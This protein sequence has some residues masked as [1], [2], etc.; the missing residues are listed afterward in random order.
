MILAAFL[1]AAPLSL[2][3]DSVIQPPEAARANS[4][5]PQRHAAPDI[6]R[7][8]QIMRDEQVKT[9]ARKAAEAARLAALDRLQRVMDRPLHELLDAPPSPPPPPPAPLPTYRAPSDGP[10]ADPTRERSPLIRCD[11]EPYRAPDTGHRWIE[12]PP[13]WLPLPAWA[14]F[15]AVAGLVAGIGAWLSWRRRKNRPDK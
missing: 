6:E 11:A 7:I 12:P 14:F 5:S 2:P 10:C 4:A 3:I 9:D 15:P 8:E 1:A 13:P